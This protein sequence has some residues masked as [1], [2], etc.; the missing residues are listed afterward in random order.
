MYDDIV[1]VGNYSLIIHSNDG[2][3]SY[4][5]IILLEGIVFVSNE[6]YNMDYVK[7]LTKRKASW[8]EG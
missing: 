7:I 8:Y 4:G 6:G 2:V 1:D 3:S 5:K